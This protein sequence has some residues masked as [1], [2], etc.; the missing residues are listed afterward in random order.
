[1]FD[2][3]DVVVEEVVA[4]GDHQGHALLWVSYGRLQEQVRRYI[5]IMAATVVAVLVCAFLISLR[6]QR[7]ISGPILRLAEVARSV[8]VQGDYSVRVSRDAADEL[9]DLYES[10]NGML[11]QMQER[12]RERDLAQEE[13]QEAQTELEQRVEERTQDLMYANMLL[14]NEIDER[15]K[16]EYKISMALREKEV[17]LREVHHRVKNNLQV[18][19]GLLALQAYETQDVELKS[20]LAV[21]RQRV[22][23]MALVHETLYRSQDLSEID[24]EEFIANIV[25]ELV[26]L[27]QTEGKPI[28]LS[29]EVDHV[30]LTLD[31]A[32]PVGLLINELVTNSLKYAFPGGR[33]GCVTVKMKR[34]RGDHRRLR[35]LVSDDGVGLPSGLDW[36][37]TR[38][39]GMQLIVSLAEQIGGQV[40]VNSEAGTS[41]GIVFPDPLS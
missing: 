1:L 23:M 38:T 22:R 11:G 35:L 33:G 8:G 24:A 5:A 40:E 6:L 16:A 26:D 37:A 27:Y 13:L 28:R 15:E 20:A 30:V 19:Y 4:N 10:F 3:D 12:E 31:L 2:S 34:V 7:T 9:G 29:T 18:I 17:L 21:S 41:V 39:L 32:V 14:N 25:K 36:R